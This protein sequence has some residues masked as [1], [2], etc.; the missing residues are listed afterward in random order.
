MR[1]TKDAI[2]DLA[3]ANG[4][5]GEKPST[6]ANA[7]GALAD[8]AGG[9]GGGGE[10]GN[11]VVVP[12]EENVSEY[13]IT[14]GMTTGEII[15]ALRAGKTVV[16]D[17]T[18]SEIANGVSY[19]VGVICTND[20]ESTYDILTMDYLHHFGVTGLDGYPHAYLGD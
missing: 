15:E 12:Y 1:T 14:F 11:V 17:F 4:Y 8:V 10:G 5:T 18:E 3:I 2:T 6:I 19:I 13:T 7:V 20:A 16:L 9:G